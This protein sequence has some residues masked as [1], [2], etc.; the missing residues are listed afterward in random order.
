MIETHEF[1]SRWWGSPVGIVTNPGFFALPADEQRDRLAAFEWVEFRMPLEQSP[2]DLPSIHAAGFYQVD[3]QINYRLNLGRL[4]APESLASLSVEF[5]DQTPF[6][7]TAG[8][9]KP[10]EHERFFKL[11]GI[12]PERVNERYALWSNEHLARHPAASLR[13]LHQGEV[14]GWYLGDDSS[15][16]G[17]NLTLAMLSRKS[18]ISGLLLFLKA[19]QAFSSRGHR[20][21]WAAFSI[22]NSPVHNI[23]ASIGARFMRP[24][25]QWLWVA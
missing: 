18:T 13:V 12:T 4:P 8:E 22:Q 9:M 24:T 1:N 25:G 15:G 21:G 19:Y 5:A 11:P 23:Y 6:T 10:F 14:E 7:V 2:V 3:T 17:L 20:L 16:V